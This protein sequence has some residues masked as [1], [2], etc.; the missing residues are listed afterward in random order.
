MDLEVATDEVSFKE[1]AE[2]FTRVTGRPAIHRKLPMSQYLDAA[3]PY[4]NAPV[5]WMAGTRGTRDDTIMTWR[6][7]FTAW[8]FYWAEGLGATRDF[9]L[10]DE[11]HPTRIRNLEGWMR[12]VNYQG[13]PKEVLKG[14]EDARGGSMGGHW[15]YNV[16]KSGS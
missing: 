13:K 4:P 14:L 15:K 16:E 1:I 12:R 7:N 3:E 11:I 2:I 6:E 5:N 10:L 9:T 8:W